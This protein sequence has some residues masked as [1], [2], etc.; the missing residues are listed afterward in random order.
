MKLYDLPA[1]PNARRVRIFIA[2]KGLDIPK[3]EIDLATGYHRSPEYL[4]KN[5]MGKMPV[6]ELDDG[7][8]IS[9]SHAICR[10]L[11]EIYPEPSLMGQTPLEKAQIEMW[12]RRIEL[13]LLNP[14]L[15]AFV[16]G[17]PMWKGIREQVAEF[18]PVCVKNATSSLEWLE[19]SLE[20]REYIATESYS[21]ADITAQCTLL[22]GKA[23]GVRAT[24]EQK[25][26]NSWWER[27]TSRPTARA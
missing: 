27:V 23:V 1:S 19:T 14:I 11:E 5:I 22:M 18:V 20:G 17:H 13:D 7:T 15:N 24:E 9:E 6:L 16:H 26:I 12:N 4:K 3:E 21:I 25:N 10:Y 8:T 2:E